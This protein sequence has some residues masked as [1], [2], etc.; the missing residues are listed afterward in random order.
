[1]SGLFL[2]RPQRR[3]TALESTSLKMPDEQLTAGGGEVF[4]LVSGAF[5]YGRPAR[6]QASREQGIEMWLKCPTVNSPFSLLVHLM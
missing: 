3:E 2:C 4:G 1:M 5:W 6:T